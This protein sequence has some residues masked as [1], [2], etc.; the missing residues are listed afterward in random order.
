MR[1][2]ALAA[3]LLHA[4]AHAGVYAY[5][6]GDINNQIRVIATDEIVDGLLVKSK[7]ELVTIP[8]RV[9][10]EYHSVR[11][12]VNGTLGLQPW[13]AD[14]V[15][16]TFETAKLNV[17]VPTNCKIVSAWGTLLSSI[18]PSPTELF[19]AIQTN[20]TV[21]FH[22]DYE[23][24]D[25]VDPPGLF[26]NGALILRGGHGC[27]PAGLASAVRFRLE[28]RRGVGTGAGLAQIS[29]FTGN[30]MIDGSK[31]L[32]EGNMGF[33]TQ[34]KGYTRDDQPETSGDNI[35]LVI[36]PGQNEGLYGVYTTTGPATVQCSG[37]ELKP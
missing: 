10:Q 33:R 29:V 22:G 30:G 3:L 32:N 20:L 14:P 24:D 8:T 1:T 12:C 2:V 21:Q 6:D 25:A 26:T 19:R 11:L 16:V 15:G 4:P 28:A 7:N 18:G 36:P 35:R 31:P 13:I 23:A 27:W 37:F 34:Q 9:N 5:N 17:P